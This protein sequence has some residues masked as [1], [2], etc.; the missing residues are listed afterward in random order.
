MGKDG[1]VGQRRQLVDDKQ[2]RCLGKP[3]GNIFYNIFI[4]IYLYIDIK[5]LN[6]NPLINGIMLFSEAMGY[7]I[8]IPVPDMGDLFLSGWLM[9]YSPLYPVNNIG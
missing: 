6:W 3:F 8:K 7:Q 9:W 4:Y 5:E 2:Q 1:N